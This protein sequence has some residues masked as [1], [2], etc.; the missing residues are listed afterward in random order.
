MAV[1]IAARIMSEAEAGKIAC[2]RTVRDL[3]VGSDLEFA[4]LGERTLKGVA[5]RMG[6]VRRAELRSAQCISSWGLLGR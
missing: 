5:R 6:T 3:A 1:H 4:P 2:S